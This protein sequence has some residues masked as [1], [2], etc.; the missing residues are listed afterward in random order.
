ME[1]KG[2]VEGKGGGKNNRFGHNRLGRL[3]D[4]YALV[5]CLITIMNKLNEDLIV[6]IYSIFFNLRTRI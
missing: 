3:Q 1:S 2:E 6:H 5:L 4:Y